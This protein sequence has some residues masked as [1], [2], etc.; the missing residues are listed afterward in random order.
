MQPQNKNTSKQYSLLSIIKSSALEFSKT[1]SIAICGMLL[2]ARVILGVYANFTLN[3]F[4]EFK[5]GFNYLPIIIAAVLF[6]PV[7]AAAIGGAGDILAYFLNPLGGAYFPGWTVSGILTGLIYG[8]FLYQQNIKLI[9]L[10]FVCLFAAI[11]VELLLGSFWLNLQFGWK[12]EV[13]LASRAAKSAFLFPIE[14]AIKFF[15]IKAL[16]KV[17]L[18][19][20]YS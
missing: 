2:A 6:G 9:R 17:K 3:L 14:T 12:F 18:I 10:I 4:Q 5:I 11:S 7:G 19:R 16:H 13:M 15:A 20:V 1:S 8:I